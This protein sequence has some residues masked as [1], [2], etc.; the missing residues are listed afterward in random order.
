MT[1]NYILFSYRP[2]VREWFSLAN[3]LLYFQ[4]GVD[5]DEYYNAYHT[6]IL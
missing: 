1:D 3:D 4:T 2:T 5:D 6:Q